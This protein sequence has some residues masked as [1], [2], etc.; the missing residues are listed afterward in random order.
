MCRLY[1]LKPTMNSQANRP[2]SGKHL[3][4]LALAICLLAAFVAARLL[5][6]DNTM[7]TRAAHAPSASEI[8]AS[9]PSITGTSA[10]EKALVAALAK[11]RTSPARADTW[12]AVGDCL[13]QRQRET[14]DPTFPAHAAAAYQQALR[15][16]PNCVEALTGMAWV[17]GV[18]HRF[19]ASI[20]WAR[21]AL[22]VAPDC[23]DACGILGDAALEL[24]DYE[25]AS[26]HYQKMMDLRPDL[27]SWS[28]GAQLLWITGESA[29][30]VSLMEQ[31][32]RSGS[33]YAENTAWCRARLAMM[34]FHQ[35]AYPAAAQALEPSLRARSK[36]PHVL[37][38][39]ARL[40][41]A[42]GDP[43][44]AREYYRMLLENGPNHDALA[45]LGD[46]EAMKGNSAEAENFYQQVID[47]HTAHRSGGVHD[48]SQMARFLA[49]HDRDPLNALRLAEQH[50]LSQN[51]HEADTLAWVYHKNGNQQAAILAIKRAL[52]HR[53]PEAEIHYHAGMIAATAGDEE[54]ARRHLST[55]VSINPRFHPIHA[56]IARKTLDRLAGATPNTQP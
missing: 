51:V 4:L 1:F 24:G 33:A 8:L 46:L 35:G 25:E 43:D 17:E 16:M 12:V 2:R 19:D 27:S 21:Q 47:L 23:A 34:L 22:Q 45:G 36:N 20:D 37:L 30:A 50:K 52:A 40:A 55:A 32:I 42:T 54:A 48:H 14:A 49:D 15:I 3:Q 7:A 6:P 10:S 53:T 41:T 56:P 11:A 18:A 13:A 29:H 9:I 5:K 28:R 38:A 26:A 39:A 44:I 31:A